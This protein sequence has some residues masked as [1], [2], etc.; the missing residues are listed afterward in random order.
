MKK[1]IAVAMLL[2]TTLCII[3]SCEEQTEV[4]EDIQNQQV[5]DVSSAVTEDKD[6]TS[7]NEP[8]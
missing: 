6:N 5:E 8:E 7:E 4:F 1:L 2:T 3:S